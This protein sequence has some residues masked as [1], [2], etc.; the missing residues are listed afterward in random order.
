MTLME[1]Y[2]HVGR[3]FPFCFVYSPS[4]WPNDIWKAESADSNFIYARLISK[5]NKEHVLI[6]FDIDGSSNFAIH[7]NTYKQNFTDLIDTP[8]TSSTEKITQNE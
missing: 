3:K 8:C 6:R 2:E 7:E 5:N 4:G 1:I